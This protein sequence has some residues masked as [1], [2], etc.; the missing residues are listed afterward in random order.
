MAISSIT[1][2]YVL[3]PSNSTLWT[4]SN[5]SGII[6]T[7]IT[8]H[9]YI[10][11]DIFLKCTCYPLYKWKKKVDLWKDFQDILVTKLILIKVRY[12]IGCMTCCFLHE[13]KMDYNETYVLVN[14][15]IHKEILEL[16]MKKL[17]M[18]VYPWMWR[19][20]ELSGWKHVYILLHMEELHLKCVM[21]Y[22][23]CAIYATGRF[24]F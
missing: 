1:N 20:W 22:V 10:N 5:P 19:G 2:S 7:Y 16:Y 3:L 21:I 18:N 24:S 23:T 8:W 4:L 11:Y 12:R 13:K 14:L 15:Y 17:I 9:M 6:F